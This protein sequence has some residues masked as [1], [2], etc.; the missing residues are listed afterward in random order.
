MERKLKNKFVFILLV[1]LLVTSC[2]SQKVIYTNTL[3]TIL[4][5]SFDNNFAKD[6]ITVFVNQQEIISNFCLRKKSDYNEMGFKVNLFSNYQTP[7]FY[8]FSYLNFSKIIQAKVR[9]NK[10]RLFSVHMVINGKVVK[11]EMEFNTLDGKYISFYKKTS[12]GMYLGWICSN[13]PIQEE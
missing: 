6:T 5:L 12:D 1:I 10:A 8:V 9:N 11:N 4:S 3:E 2:R 13:T 7:S